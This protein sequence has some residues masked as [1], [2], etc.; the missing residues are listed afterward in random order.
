MVIAPA[1][2]KVAGAEI[3][4][5]DGVA[6]TVT[7]RVA[8]LLPQILLTV[9]VTGTNPP[10]MPVTTPLLLTVAAP[11]AAH[12]PPAGVPLSVVVD[13]AHKTAAPETDGVAG[14]PFTKRFCEAVAIP[15]TDVTV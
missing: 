14:A 12:T 11:V 1:T 15:Q 7:K 3:L 4:P 8:K 10:A 6:L 13:P 9:Y 5:A 2:H